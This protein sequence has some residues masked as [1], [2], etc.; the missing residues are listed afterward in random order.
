MRTPE[1]PLQR[2][3]SRLAEEDFPR[4]GECHPVLGRGPSLA[5]AI[6]RDRYVEI[7]GADHFMFARD[8]TVQSTIA[9]FLA[10]SM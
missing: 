3:R 2:D 7:P 9:E 1:P 10:A 6:P 8:E 5:Q 4:V